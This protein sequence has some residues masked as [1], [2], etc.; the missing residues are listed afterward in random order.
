MTRIFRFITLVLVICAT[1]SAF[2]QNADLDK[3]VY[4]I[5]S[6][7]LT[8]PQTSHGP[9]NN[10][11]YLIAATTG[12]GVPKEPCIRPPKEREADRGAD[13]REVIADYHQR[14]ATP[15]QLS[16]TLSIEKPYLLLSADE[17]TEFQQARAPRPPGSSSADRFQGVIDLFTLSD[18]YF[19]QY[20]TLALTAISSFCG[21]LCGFHQWRVYERIAGHPWED[22]KW[23]AC[24]VRAEGLQDWHFVP[25]ALRQK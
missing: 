16:R 4:A 8:N 11:L 6:L 5:Y 14:E 25:V 24:I 17:V 19:N 23:A 12:P 15:R 21:G 7:M 18:V 3:D 2:Q 10:K 22:T 20:R 1:S 9:D 13:F